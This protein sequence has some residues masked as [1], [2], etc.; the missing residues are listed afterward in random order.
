VSEVEGSDLERRCG[1]SHHQGAAL[2]CGP[3]PVAGERECLAGPPGERALLLALD[4]VQDPRNFGA[5]VRCAAVFGIDGM[6]VPRH[7]SAPLS[8][9][10]SKAS[11]GYL[12]TFPLYVAPNLA[13]F[14]AAARKQGYWVA[15]TGEGGRTPLHAFVRD[16]PLVVVMGNEG[17]GLRPLVRKLCDFELAIR[18]QGGGSLN[19]ATATA[20][21]L[22]H[23][24]LPHG[25]GEKPA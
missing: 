20:V 22:Y 13:R 21:V 25:A 3:L 1:S 2:Q 18:T 19:V 9:V 11:A 12:E 16:R 10:V 5:A 14:L 4:E 7:H 15:G 17:R 8:P 23:L 24:T 6:V